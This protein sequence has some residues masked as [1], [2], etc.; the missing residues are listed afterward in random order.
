MTIEFN[1]PQR[2]PTFQVTFDV[3]IDS[4]LL[5]PRVLFTAEVP[6]NK[7]LQVLYT[8]NK[9]KDTDAYQFKLDKQ[10]FQNDTEV[11]R[12]IL[13]IYPKLPNQDFV[14]PP[15]DEEIVPFIKDLGY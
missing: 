8:I 3:S 4:L 6:R 15:S 5:S 9:I 12:E 14:K 1:K 2:E 13:Q 7:M 11:F 10:K